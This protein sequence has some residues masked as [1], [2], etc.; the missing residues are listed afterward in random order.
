M[1][2]QGGK[3]NIKGQKK[4]QIIRKSTDVITKCQSQNQNI[5]HH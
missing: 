2:L 3:F 4:H 5:D 1:I